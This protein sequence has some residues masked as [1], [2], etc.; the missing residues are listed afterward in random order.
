MA[1]ELMRLQ[2]Y[3]GLSSNHSVRRGSYYLKSMAWISAKS[4]SDV[5]SNRKHFSWPDDVQFVG[6]GW[7]KD[8]DSSCA[9]RI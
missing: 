5:V 9:A 4:H 8:Y 2:R 3:P 6:Q 1:T 7:G